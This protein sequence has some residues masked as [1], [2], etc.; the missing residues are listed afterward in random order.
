MAEYKDLRQ[1]NDAALDRFPGFGFITNQGFHLG[2]YRIRKKQAPAFQIVNGWLIFR[3]FKKNSI[4]NWE[5]P[6]IKGYLRC[7]FFYLQRE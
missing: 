1:C 4:Q 5:I 6:T 2:H 7:K 3:V